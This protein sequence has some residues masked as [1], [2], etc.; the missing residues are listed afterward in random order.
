MC[1]P[2][3]EYALCTYIWVCMCVFVRCACISVHVE[4]RHWLCALSCFLLYFLYCV[5]V[6]SWVCMVCVLCFFI[7]C[8]YTCRHAHV[9]GYTCTAAQVWKS[10]WGAVLH[11]HFVRQLPA[12]DPHACDK[13]FEPLRHRCGP[14]SYFLESSSF[15][16]S[17]AHWSALLPAIRSRVTCGVTLRCTVAPHRAWLLLNAGF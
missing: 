10:E 4:V 16:V 7:W 14:P 3:C 17:G 13:Y 1:A 2:M 5:S 9:Y 15:I 8:M 6:C 11:F 12:S